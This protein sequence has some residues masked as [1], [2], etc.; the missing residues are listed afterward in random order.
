MTVIDIHTHSLSD[1]WL[2]LVREKG[3]PDLDIGTDPDGGELLIEYGT[4]SM[5]FHTAMFDYEGRLRDMDAQGIDISVVSLTS[6]NA[7]WGTAE[8]SNE[9]A[10]IIN[11]DMAAAQTAYPDR[12]RF[13]ATIPWEYSELAAIELERAVGLG[14]VGVMTLANIRE[15]HLNDPLFNPIWAD[16]EKRGLPVLV[17]P[18]VPLGAEKMDLGTYRLLGPIGFMFD[19]SLAISRMIMDGFFDRFPNLKVI[20]SHAGGYLP[21]VSKC[22]DLFFDQIPMDKKITDLPSS[23]LQRIYYDSII[24]QADGLQSLINLAG[25]DRVMFGTDYPHVADIPVLK[26]LAEGLPA[27]QS[28]RVLGK[29]AEAIFDF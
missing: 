4:P 7:I 18:T 24:Y 14:A 11:N 9:C 8:I 21:Y 5:G 28:A 17:H 19:T 23:Y 26:N 20:A 22:M 15:K 2:K 16:I 10:Q 3:K 25:P 13:F 12:I 27:D 29:A 1:N 6:P